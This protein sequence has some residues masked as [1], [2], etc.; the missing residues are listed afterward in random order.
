MNRYLTPVDQVFRLQD[1]DEHAEGVVGSPISDAERRELQLWDQST[2]L[3][4]RKLQHCIDFLADGYV[5]SEKRKCGICRCRFRVATLFLL[6]TMAVLLLL[7]GLVVN[8]YSAGCCP[9]RLSEW[10]VSGFGLNSEIQ[11]CDA[12]QRHATADDQLGREHQGCRVRG[13]EHE[14]H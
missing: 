10:G 1:V 11:T 4:S 13:L 6:S 3:I 9:E 5:G 8:H 7:I 14:R 2:Q 12:A